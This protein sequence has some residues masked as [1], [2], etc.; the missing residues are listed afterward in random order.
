MERDDL[1]QRGTSVS[2]MFF[3]PTIR[4]SRGP[5]AFPKIV[6]QSSH[7]VIRQEGIS[8]H[9]APKRLKRIYGTS[10]AALD[11]QDPGRSQIFPAHF[12]GLIAEYSTL[13]SSE[14]KD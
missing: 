9:P 1:F 13:I 6:L 2:F 10:V 12:H 4:Q 7:A 14:P 11:R 5:E 3:D 8:L